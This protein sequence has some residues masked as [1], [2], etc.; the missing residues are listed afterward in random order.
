MALKIMRKIQ[1]ILNQHGELIGTIMGGTA[2]VFPTR[3]ISGGINFA[4]DRISHWKIPDVGVL[5]NQIMTNAPYRKPLMNG[6]GLYVAG[7][8]AKE[9]KIPVVKQYSPGMQKLGQGMAQGALLAAIAL[10]P[11]LQSSNPGTISA[12]A[13]LSH[14]Q[15]YAY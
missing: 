2:D 8:I 1:Q 6:I 15:G 9:L 4:M 13:A 14:V 10:L 11:A 3:G 12:G 7:W 5:L